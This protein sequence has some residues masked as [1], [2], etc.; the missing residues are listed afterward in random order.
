MADHEGIDMTNRICTAPD[1]DATIRC[2]GLCVLHYDRWRK[3][4]PSE[5]RQMYRSSFD[6]RFDAKTTPSGDCLVWTGARDPKGYG[7]L[8]LP[9][10][11]TGFAH[12]YALERRLGRPITPGMFACHRCD[13]PS[14]VKAD[15]LYEGSDQDNVN[16]M[17]SQARHAWGERNGHHKL[18]TAQVSEIRRLVNT[19][20][21]HRSVASM[22]DVNQSTVSRIATGRRWAL[23]DVSKSA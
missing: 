3:A 4:V 9:G 11:R 15:H 23:A 7:R 8:G 20:M 16:D 18:T 19:G 14:C 10:R 22:F 1:C 6:E 13:N 21:S 2:R 17:T 12:R 5:E